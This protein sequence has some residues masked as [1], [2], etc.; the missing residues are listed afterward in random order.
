[1]YF[2]VIRHHRVLFCDNRNWY[3]V[4]G[5]KVLAVYKRRRPAVAYF[6]EC[7]LN[8]GPVLEWANKQNWL[9]HTIQQSM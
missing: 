7:F 1:M 8:P 3:T 4:P 9:W 2:I 5:D 6:L